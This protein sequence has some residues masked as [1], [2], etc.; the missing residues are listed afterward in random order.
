[1]AAEMVARD[2][3]NSRSTGAMRTLAVARIAAATR[4]TRNVAPATRQA[5]WMRGIPAMMP[6]GATGSSV[7]EVAGEVAVGGQGPAGRE[8]RVQL[9]PVLDALLAELPA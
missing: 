4:S 1:M 9:V 2:Q 7:Q 6:A 5:G 8:T 3:P